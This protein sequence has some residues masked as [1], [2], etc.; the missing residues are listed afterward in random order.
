M[1][2]LFFLLLHMSTTAQ[3][4]TLVIEASGEETSYSFYPEGVDLDQPFSQIDGALRSDKQERLRTFYEK[5]QVI[6]ALHIALE[7]LDS[8][9][10]LMKNLNQ[11]AVRAGIELVPFSVEKL[12]VGV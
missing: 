7:T 10:N 6:K 12:K 1:Q 8:S 5:E 4:D 3:S 2:E 9:G 11:T